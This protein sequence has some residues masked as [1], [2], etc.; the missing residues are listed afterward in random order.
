MLNT[1][2]LLFCTFCSHCCIPPNP[3][4]IRTLVI[5]MYLSIHHNDFPQVSLVLYD[6]YRPTSYHYKLKIKFMILS[7]QLAVPPSTSLRTP[8]GVFL[9]CSPAPR[10]FQHRS[11]PE[12]LIVTQPPNVVKCTSK[13]YFLS[14]PSSQ[15]ILIAACHILQFVICTKDYGNNHSPDFIVCRH[16]LPEICHCYKIIPHRGKFRLYYL[17][18]QNL[19]TSSHCLST[20]SDK[21]TRA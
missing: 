6:S 16:C 10:I 9:L 14:I 8:N 4:L 2:L 5:A 15:F 19:S 7:S 21:I 3:T 18:S 1:F 12:F 11:F 17:S 13:I 20:E